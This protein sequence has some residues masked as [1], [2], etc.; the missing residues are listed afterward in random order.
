MSLRELKGLIS[1][2][3]AEELLK[4]QQE[5]QRSKGSAR[6]SK[7]TKKGKVGDRRKSFDLTKKTEVKKRPVSKQES[8]EVIVKLNSLK[9]IDDSELIKT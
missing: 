5:S 6:Q 8:K 1:R 3:V 7:N 4:Q 2:L 9:E